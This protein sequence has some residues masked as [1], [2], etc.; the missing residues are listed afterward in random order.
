MTEKGWVVVSWPR[1]SLTMRGFVASGARVW[2]ARPVNLPGPARTCAQAMIDA[3]GGYVPCL[4]CG[5]DVW[6]MDRTAGRCGLC[7]S[8]GIGETR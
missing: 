2:L 3:R 7:V 8:E 6:Y 4:T 1:L 5:A